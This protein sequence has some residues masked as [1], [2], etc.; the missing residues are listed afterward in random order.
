MAW[1]LAARVRARE[2]AG[3][4]LGPTV[5]D[6]RRTWEVLPPV[7]H[8]RLTECP[9][10]VLRR[11]SD[12]GR[13]LLAFSRQLTSLLAYL[14]TS[15]E[16]AV[17]NFARD[18]DRCFPPS[19]RKRQRTDGDAGDRPAQ[20]PRTATDPAEPPTYSH[21]APPHTAPGEGAAERQR[22]GEAA[23][24][25]RSMFPPLWT[26]S[27]GQAHSCLHPDV[28]L[29]TKSDRF[30][31]VASM[32]A[33]AGAEGAAAPRSAVGGRSVALHVIRLQDGVCTA[34]MELP[35]GVE[36]SGCRGLDLMGSLLTVTCRST[37]QIWILQLHPS[38]D[39]RTLHEI[40]GLNDALALPPLTAPNFA[41]PLPPRAPAARTAHEH[42]ADTEHHTTM[43]GALQQCLLS[44]LLRSIM[45]RDSAGG[46]GEGLAWFYH[47]F[48]LLAN[49]C[50][51]RAVVVGQQHLAVMFE[52]PSQ[53]RMKGSGEFTSRYLTGIYDTATG[54]IEKLWGGW[55]LQLVSESSSD[56]MSAR[57]VGCCSLWD[58][59]HPTSTARNVD[60][61]VDGAAAHG[62]AAAQA[63]AS[64]N[65]RSF[66]SSSPLLD[67]AIFRCVNDAAHASA[68]AP[69]F[70]DPLVSLQ[71]VRATEGGGAEGGARRSRQVDVT[72]VA[73]PEERG[74]A[75]APAMV[76]CL[77]HP[78]LPMILT[79]SYDSG[80]MQA[81]VQL[82][83]E[84]ER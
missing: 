39:L 64:E 49:A 12:S 70:H 57:A 7:H 52:V 32:G 27:V 63:S 29:I 48:D 38:G 16:G 23:R 19:T 41:H 60:A 10:V 22:G 15:G 21:G 35:E 83:R 13:L 81:R 67:G 79:A 17:S 9:E 80:G 37:Q 5:H 30:V 59:E 28:F 45:Q 44:S 69:P 74:M 71:P 62:A 2:T 42:G 6:L 76:S 61:A 66:T 20:A 14:V 43:L 58:R 26:W 8:A 3:A 77:F 40:G 33:P 34:S 25:F 54:K 36:L 47:Q 51:H 65:P 1:N 72:P 75:S 4:P 56:I 24:T 55:N 50:A 31:I 68:H 82:V 84:P 46:R 11:F 78:A 53:L 73:N 18:R